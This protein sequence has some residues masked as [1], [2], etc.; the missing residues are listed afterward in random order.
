M[1]G[2]N[3]V[4]LIGNLG[5][6]P[7]SKTLDGGNTVTNFS[8]ATSESYKDKKGEKVDKTEWHN[9]AVWGKLAEV[10]AKYLKKG[11]SVYVEGK[12]QTRTW[13]DKDGNKRYSTDIIANNFT[14]LGGKSEGGSSTA[15]PETAS[16]EGDSS[17]LP[18]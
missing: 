4:I 7:E 1:A 11:S 13:D 9:I 18:F 16:A 12:I 3:K 10:A 17:D 6:E 2:V 8:L 15:Q 5:K 14:M